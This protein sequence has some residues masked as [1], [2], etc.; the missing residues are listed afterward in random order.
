MGYW[1]I[2]HANTVVTIHGLFPAWVFLFVQ[3]DAAHTLL[4][5]ARLLSAWSHYKR[6]YIY[7]MHR[8]RKGTHY[9]VKAWCDY[10]TLYLRAMLIDGAY[11]YIPTAGGI[12]Q[13]S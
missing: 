7:V 3:C 12:H 9:A 1:G 13:F 11:M 5:G 10:G 4:N 6:P 8:R 2:R